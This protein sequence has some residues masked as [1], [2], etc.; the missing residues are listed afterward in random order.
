MLIYWT[1]GIVL[2]LK[3][4]LM[5]KREGLINNNEQEAIL[6]QD[7]ANHTEY[8]SEIFKKKKMIIILLKY[9]H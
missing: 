3:K 9:S 6:L 1:Q 2:K 4:F 8:K 7:V 5:E